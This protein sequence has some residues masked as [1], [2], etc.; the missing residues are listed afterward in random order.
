MSN[1]INTKKSKSGFSP[2]GLTEISE[3]EFK[4]FKTWIYDA[5]G[6]NLSDHK[7]TLVMGRLAPRLRH[8]KLSKYGDYFSLLTS[9]KET[10]ELQ[11]AIDL[12]TTNETY[13]FRE[14]KHFDF[15]RDQIL[16]AHPPGQQMRIWSAASSTGEEP[17]TIAMTLAES[18]GNGAWEIIASDISSRV[19][20]RARTGHYSMERARHIPQTLLHKYCLKGVG[21]QDGTFMINAELKRRVKFQ[22]INLNNPLPQLGEFN[23]III[24]NVMIYFDQDTKRKVIARMLPYLK[25]G[26]Y[27]LIGHSESLNGITDKL[28]TIKP[29]IYRKP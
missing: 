23:V 11:I 12:L 1:E 17:Y 28:E 27:L 8:H 18:L 21:E 7:R 5:A 2:T 25:R 26:G 14:P 6:I 24:R 29:S 15:L 19:L 10:V 22:Y 4:K 3:V 16:K 20:D 9:P 13:F